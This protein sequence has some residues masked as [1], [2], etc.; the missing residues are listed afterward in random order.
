[1]WY[2]LAR[3]ILDLMKWV[4]LSI[5]VVIGVG[6][7]ANIAPLPAN[8][9]YKNFYQSA[10]G[11]FFRPGLHLTLTL[12]I[13][14]LL[15]LLTVTCWLIARRAPEKPAGASQQIVNRQRGR[16]VSSSSIQKQGDGSM[17]IV[18]RSPGAVVT[19]RDDREPDLVPGSYQSAFVGTGLAPSRPLR[20]LVATSQI[21]CLSSRLWGQALWPIPLKEAPE[22][23]R[24]KAP[25]QAHPPPRSLR[26]GHHPALC[27]SRWGIW[28]FLLLPRPLL[29]SPPTP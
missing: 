20:S 4:W 9:V 26:M 21:V 14:T 17:V 13:F 7:V 11:W 12:G 18:D 2:C 29:L 19:L 16:F 10:M 5:V 6:Y 28:H 22:Q 8:E 24:R 25:T 15:L 1:M 27:R 3:A 23:D